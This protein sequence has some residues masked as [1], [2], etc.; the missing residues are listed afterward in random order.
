MLRAHLLKHIIAA[1]A[2]PP[3]LVVR[4]QIFEDVLKT[5]GAFGQRGQAAD[6]PSNIGV[7]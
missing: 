6:A 2:A 5:F 3:H 7:Q 4:G 1:L